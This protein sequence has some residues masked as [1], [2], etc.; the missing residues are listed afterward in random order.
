MSRE[1]GRYNIK[2]RFACIL[3]HIGYVCEI[4]AGRFCFLRVRGIFIRLSSVMGPSA[5]KKM[6]NCP[7]ICEV[8]G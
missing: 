2:T 4:C 5:C 3:V 8:V 7:F 6:T 1:N